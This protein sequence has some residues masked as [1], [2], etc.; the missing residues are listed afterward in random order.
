MKGISALAERLSRLSWRQLLAFFP[1]LWRRVGENGLQ[2]TAGHLAY[3]SLLSLVPMMAVV[4]S[5][6]SAFPGFAGVRADLEAFVYNNFVPTA[7]DTVQQYLGQFVD[8]A[9]RMTAVGVLFLAVVALML[10]SNIDKALNR[11]WKVQT[12]RRAIYSF[13]MYW[14]ILTLGPMLMGASL[15]VTSYLVSMKLFSDAGLSGAYAFFIARLPF[16]LSVSA[17]ALLYMMV[18]NTRVRFHHA[19]LGAFVAALLFEAG[20]RGFAWYVTQ[21][22]SYEAIYGALATIPILFLWVYLSWI[23]VLL[24]AEV[25]AALPEYFHLDDDT[26]KEST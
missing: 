21:F 25:T 7:G 26:D 24:G 4:L 6:F 5:V 13:S 17:F 8:N 20:K 23:I 1:Y 9:S 19:L 3:V 15:A 10:I 16:L 2:V 14:M 22:P 18:P 12:R 11:I